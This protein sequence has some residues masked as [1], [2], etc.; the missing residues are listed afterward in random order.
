MPLSLVGSWR[1]PQS[2]AI[3]SFYLIRDPRSWWLASQCVRPYQTWCFRHY[4]TLPP[5]RQ[6]CLE[7]TPT[8]PSI[9]FAWS[10]RELCLVLL[11]Q[12]Q[13]PWAALWLCC[14]P[15]LGPKY[16]RWTGQIRYCICWIQVIN[17]LS[18]YSKGELHWFET[19]WLFTASTLILRCPKS[20]WNRRIST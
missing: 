19:Y 5:W 6:I 20:S 17:F 10:I 8:F 9:L 18:E 14:R 1:A 11:F 16:W 13:V 3:N 2:F 15:P 7:L 4:V 12:F